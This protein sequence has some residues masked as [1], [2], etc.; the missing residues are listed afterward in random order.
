MKLTLGFSKSWGIGENH[1]TPK[2]FPN[3]KRK[4][5]GEDIFGL[6][7]SADRTPTNTNGNITSIL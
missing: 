3:G 5:D 4:R 6:Q 7:E 1:S 2:Y